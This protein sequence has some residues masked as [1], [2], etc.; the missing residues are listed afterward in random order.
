MFAL[1]LLYIFL[2]CIFSWYDLFQVTGADA[3]CVLYII[4]IS[5]IL[6]TV[7]F[8]NQI[9]ICS[10]SVARVPL[11]LSRLL[12]PDAL[13]ADFEEAIVLV[14]CFMVTC[15]LSWVLTIY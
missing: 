2:V 12:K 6:F 8:V 4:S 9:M 11:V 13:A 1:F 3:S 10:T 15:F 5:I 7:L 14:I